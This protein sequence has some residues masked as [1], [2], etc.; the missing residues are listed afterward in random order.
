MKLLSLHASQRLSRWIFESP[1]S[2]KLTID[3]YYFIRNTGLKDIIHTHKK[4][5]LHRHEDKDYFN[6]TIKNLQLLTDNL[7]FK[8]PNDRNNLTVLFSNQMRNK[9]G[10]LA[11]SFQLIKTLTELNKSRDSLILIEVERE[12]EMW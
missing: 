8:N 6:T 12:L 9:V 4:D 7:N 2:D 3:Y 5:N 11:K 10:R 1:H